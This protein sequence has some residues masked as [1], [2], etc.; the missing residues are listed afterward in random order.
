MTGIKRFFLCRLAPVS[1]DMPVAD[2]AQI[3][4]DAA[5]SGVT[6]THKV[7]SETVGHGPRGDAFDWDFMIEVWLDAPD[8]PDW[9]RLSSACRA[10]G[11][12]AAGSRTML[13]EELIMKQGS[14]AVKGTFLSK[15]R[16]DASVPEYQS[17]WRNEH[18]E[19]IMAQT[20]FFAFV[21]A[22]VQNHFF[23]GSFLSLEGVAPAREE[24]FDGAPQMWFDSPEDIYDAFQTSGY[25]NA[26]KED[27]KILT[28]VGQSQSFISR[29]TE[30]P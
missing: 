16:R 23:P 2:R 30:L 4:L 29:E 9:K 18:R 28:W 1:A 10:A 14:A 19:I 24:T 5:L 20:D 6:V 22:Y 17:Y 8:T 13:A 12:D 7:L 11:L 21:R 3:L 27:E 15:R 25:L 26:I